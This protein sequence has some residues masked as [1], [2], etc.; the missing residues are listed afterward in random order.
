MSQ[1]TKKAGAIGVKAWVAGVFVYLSFAI[2]LATFYFPGLSFTLHS[3]NIAPKDIISPRDDQIVDKAATDAARERAAASVL[4][5]YDFDEKVLEN[6]IKRID[7]LF[8]LVIETIRDKTL[9]TDAQKAEQLRFQIARSNLGFDLKPETITKLAGANTAQIEDL[10]SG[11]IDVTRSLLIK[12]INEEGIK[13][14]TN[15][16]ETYVKLRPSSQW[17]RNL[18]LEITKF[19]VA[20]N[21]FVNEEQTRK[22]RDYAKNRISP[23]VRTVSEGEIIVMAG[24]PITPDAMAIIEYLGIARNIGD[25]RT[26]LAIALYPLILVIF[27][28]MVIAISNKIILEDTT[29]ITLFVI[30]VIIS[31]AGARFLVPISPFLALTPFVAIIMTIFLGAQVSIPVMLLLSPLGVIFKSIASAPVSGTM[32]L[33]FG[34]ALIGYMTCLHLPKVKRFTHFVVVIVYSLIG[35][36]LASSLFVLFSTLDKMGMLIMVAIALGSTTVQ[37]ALALALTPFLELLTTHTTVFR[38]LE[39]SDLNHPLLRKLMI[40][41]PGTY[42]HSILVGNM[43]SIACDEIGANGLLARVGGYYHD[44]GKLKYPH[45][46]IENQQGPNPH[47]SLSPGLSKTIITKH[48]SEGL[49]LARFYKLPQEIMGFV[50]THHGTS[51]VG[52][53]LLKAREKDPETEEDDFRYQGSHPRTIEQAVVM[54]A[55]TIESASRACQMQNSFCDL[56]DLIERLVDEKLRDGQLQDSPISLSQL[57]AVKESFKKQLSA[58]YHKRIPYPAEVQHG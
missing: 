37:V 15:D 11:V 29:K 47:D 4:T 28:Y 52:F 25:W 23:I 45:Y 7:A 31:I 48:V 33:S 53:F 54:L 42:Q 55:D 24:E 5:S 35:T 1:K 30:L 14:I 36:V 49:E 18:L 57:T 41:A 46:F 13:N 6:S 32:A 38:L 19:T 20:Q 12:G 34:F 39:L 17:T 22:N 21:M 27:L 44:I 43:A 56:D 8:D 40:E 51:L 58:Q 3:G 16:I 2:L 9:L 26:W 50:D 10:R